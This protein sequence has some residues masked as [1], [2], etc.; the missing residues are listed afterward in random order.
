[1]EQV[2][3]MH[4]LS[5]LAL[6]RA[7]R[8]QAVAAAGVPAMLCG[9]SVSRC[10]S[11]GRR[12]CGSFSAH[13]CARCGRAFG[14]TLSHQALSVQRQPVGA[15]LDGGAGDQVARDGSCAFFLLRRRLR[16]Q[17]SPEAVGR[18]GGPA[19]GGPARGGKAAPPTPLSARGR[20]R[21]DGTAR[22]PRQ[23]RRAWSASRSRRLPP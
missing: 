2:E 17:R 5:R 22:G 15:R 12:R 20:S 8:V 21:Q 9:A 4:W 1:M 18:C 19:R 23:E 7:A 11:P 10:A 13:G 6:P 3:R 16:R 14:S